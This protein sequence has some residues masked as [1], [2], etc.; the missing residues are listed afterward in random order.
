MDYYSES[1]MIRAL[2]QPMFLISAEYKPVDMWYFTIQGFSGADYDVVLTP[3]EM[4][5]TC[6]DFKKRKKLCKHLYFVI[7]KIAN[8]KKSLKRLD[9]ITNIFEINTKL[10]NQLK[11]RL[12]KRI[13]EQTIDDDDNDELTECVICFEDIKKCQRDVSC[14]KCKHTFHKTCIERWLQNKENCPL[15]RTNMVIS[16][17]CVL[18]DNNG[19][20]QFD[21]L[22]INSV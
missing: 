6:P 21:R 9:E 19:L 8:D 1:R 17:L 7:A 11:K 4:S 3:E 14:T 10:T 20:A 22:V 5:C 2:N 13:E 12:Q 16:K 18:N 15:C